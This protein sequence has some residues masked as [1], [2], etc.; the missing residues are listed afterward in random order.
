MAR[1]PGDAELARHGARDRQGEVGDQEV[2]PAP[3]F[4]ERAQLRTE[5]A[6]ESEVGAELG[7]E[8]QRMEAHGVRRLDDGAD[9]RVAAGEERDPFEAGRRDLLLGLFGAHHSD[10]MLPRQP[11][12]DAEERV[13]MAGEG[14]RDEIDPG[15]QGLISIVSRSSRR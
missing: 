11:P 3:V 7:M 8:A 10:R 5:I 9:L 14:G 15:G 4:P 6:E 12:G 2:R 13:E 1:P